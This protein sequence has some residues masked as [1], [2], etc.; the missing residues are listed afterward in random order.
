MPEDED[1]IIAL[2]EEADP[3][4]ATQLKA[5]DEFLLTPVEDDDDDEESGSQVIALED[6]AAYDA[7]AATMLGADQMAMQEALVADDADMFGQQLDAYNQQAPAGAGAAQPMQMPVPMQGGYAE[8]PEAPYS[9][10]NVLALMAVLMFMVVAAL[11]M[12]DVVNNMWGFQGVSSHSTSIMD[13]I[14][15]AVGL[16]D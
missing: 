15:S 7:D 5:D 10:L 2:E 3:D 13:L 11:M 6:S 16:G 4:A 8:L 9:L 1:D 14:V 12:V